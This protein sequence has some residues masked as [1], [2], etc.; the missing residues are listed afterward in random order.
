MVTALAPGVALLLAVSVS[1][2]DAEELVGPNDAVTP[3]GSP[4]AEKATVPLKPFCC[5]TE[6]EVVALAP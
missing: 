4:N 5:V 3:A 1:K 2:L 6:T